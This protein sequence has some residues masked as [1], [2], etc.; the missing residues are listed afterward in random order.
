MFFKNCYLTYQKGIFQ[1]LICTTG[2]ST[3]FWQRLWKRNSRNTGMQINQKNVRRNGPIKTHIHTKYHLIW[4][5]PHWET[6]LSLTFYLNSFWSPFSQRGNK[7]FWW[8]F[9]CTSNKYWSSCFEHEILIRDNLYYKNIIISETW[10]CDE[11]SLPISVFERRKH[12]IT[13]EK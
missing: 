4:F 11:F 1:C 5:L 10:F 8:Q 6:G 3:G 13:A 9:K 2:W 12:Y 7:R